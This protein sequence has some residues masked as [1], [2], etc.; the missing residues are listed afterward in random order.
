M[1]Y[2]TKTKLILPFRNTWMVSN[3][4]RTVETNNHMK[5]ADGDAYGKSP[6]CSI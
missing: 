5:F 2:Q 4:G 6:S 1:D 3:G